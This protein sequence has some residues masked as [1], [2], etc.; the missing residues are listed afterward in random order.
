[1]WDPR[2]GS[3]VQPMSWQPCAANVCVQQGWLSLEA[4]FAPCEGISQIFGASGLQRHQE[5]LPWQQS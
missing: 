5:L 2:H 4:G 1:M 3:L